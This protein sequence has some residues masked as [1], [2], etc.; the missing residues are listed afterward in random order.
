VEAQ[1]GTKRQSENGRLVRL[2]LIG[3]EQP[4]RRQKAT[5]GNGWQSIVNLGES[6]ILAG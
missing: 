5:K 6:L 2:P 4:W 1:K 3:S